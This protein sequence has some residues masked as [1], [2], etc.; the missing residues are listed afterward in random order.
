MGKKGGK[1]RVWSTL[2]MMRV[3]TKEV[4]T[5]IKRGSNKRQAGDNLLKNLCDVLDVSSEG[6]VS[7]MTHKFLVW[8]TG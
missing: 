3:S 2:K 5:S 6:K 1:S 8:V 7:R 4:A